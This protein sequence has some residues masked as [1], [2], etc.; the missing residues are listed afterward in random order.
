MMEN[1]APPSC[2]AG[3]RTRAGFAS[4]RL[5]PCREQA[6]AG[7]SANPAFCSVPL[8][9]RRPWSRSKAKFYVI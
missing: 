6:E 2:L 9:L 3:C 8:I 4:P 7:G 5:R 1:A